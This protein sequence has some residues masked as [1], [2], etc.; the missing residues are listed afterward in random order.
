MSDINININI[1]FLRARGG[2]TTPRK[3]LDMALKSISVRHRLDITLTRTLLNIR[4]SNTRQYKQFTSNNT[5]RHLTK[6]TN[7]EGNNA[8]KI[9]L[10]SS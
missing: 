10:I 4:N 5:T 1:K 3:I 8:T 6:Q 7:L 2:R 9:V